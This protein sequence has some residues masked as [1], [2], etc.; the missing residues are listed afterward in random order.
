MKAFK[1][2]LIISMVTI[3][4]VWALFS[5]T[6]KKEGTQNYPW[7]ISVNTQGHL[8]VFGLIIDESSIIDS[9]N[10]LNANPKLALLQSKDKSLAL[11][12]D[13]GEHSFGLITGRLLAN[14]DISEEHKQRLKKN[15]VKFTGFES[16]SA[17]MSL[18]HE[19]AIELLTYPLNGFT[20]IPYGAFDEQKVLKFF[21]TPEQRIKENET[22][23]HFLY[24][25]KGLSIIVD[26]SGKEV[27]QYVSPKN[28]SRLKSPL[29]LLLK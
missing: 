22:M 1:L 14:I 15:N 8:K 6:E 13:L 2:S 4:F 17:K 26:Q 21:G 5:L 29:T 3:V 19:D 10:L 27:F 18:D 28:F 24:P 23:E 9:K 7:D 11:E 12:L 20:F 16:G 25:E